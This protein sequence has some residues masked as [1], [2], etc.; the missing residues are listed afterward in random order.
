M[1]V[2]ALAGGLAAVGVAREHAEPGLEGRD[3]LGTGRGVVHRYARVGGANLVIDHLG[4]AL[5]RAVARL[6]V[7]VGRPVVGEILGEGA[8]GAGGDLGDVGVGAG[9]HGRV[10]CVLLG[11]SRDFGR[12]GEVW[13]RRTPPTT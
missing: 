8:R 13:G 9:G 4:H 1:H 11:V 12:R 5:V 7:D 2:L 3:G 6:E 10:E